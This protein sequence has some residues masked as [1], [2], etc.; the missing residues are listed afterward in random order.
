MA[1]G[2]KGDRTRNRILGV[3]DDL[4]TSKGFSA[5]TMIEICQR[6]GLSRGGLSRYYSST[7]DV[8]KG[9]IIKRGQ[10]ALYEYNEM[11]VSH[12]SPS[13]MVFNFIIKKLERMSQK[14]STIDKA[15][16]EFVASGRG[17][18]E[19]AYE[20]AETHVRILASIIR[21]G[22]EQGAFIDVDSNDLARSI[23]W[24]IQGMTTYSSFITFSHDQLEKYARL[25]IKQISVR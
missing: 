14:Q 7:S 22:Q 8:L 12:I 2:G 11:V 18:S 19:F 17:G 25:R 1:N 4:F 9:V 21:S 23:L 15:V 24:E 16:I 6:A 13:E 10:D 20:N 3:A 5:V